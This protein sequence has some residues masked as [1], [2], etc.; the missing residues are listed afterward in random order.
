[1]SEEPVSPPPPGGP[2]AAAPAGPPPGPQINV[3]IPEQR[4]EILYSDQALLS[5]TPM[6]FVIDFAQLTVPLGVARVVSRIG[7]SPVHMKMLAQAAFQN[8]QAYESQ[9]GEIVLQA[10]H[11]EMHRS[12]GFQTPASAGG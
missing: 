1:M 9:F 12:I 4:F 2:P 7:M 10:G 11:Q 8:V 5:F 6:G 3:Q